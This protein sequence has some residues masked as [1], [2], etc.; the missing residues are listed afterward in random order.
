ML[1][2]G[3]LLVLLRG[4]AFRDGPR[5]SDK[6]STATNVSAAQLEALES[7]ERAALMPVR[8]SGWSTL[9][10]AD[11]VCPRPFFPTLRRWLHSENV[12]SRLSRLIRFPRATTQG[13]SLNHSLSWV[14][15]SLI[16][17]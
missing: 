13:A 15:L 9:L 6:S 11:V 4:Q 1:N 14:L 3:T 17:I 8:A 10:M 2:N 7:I 12:G 5:M 16:H